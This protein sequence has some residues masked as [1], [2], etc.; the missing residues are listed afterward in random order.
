MIK[1]SNKKFLAFVLFSYGLLF[2]VLALSAPAELVCQLQF[3]KANCWHNYQVNLSI[4]DAVNLQEITAL[5]LDSDELS[6]SSS[7]N[8]TSNQLITFTTDFSPAIWEDQQNR[9]YPAKTI[10]NVP[11][12]LDSD[13]TTWEINLCF[14]DDFSGVPLPP[15]GN[16]VNCRC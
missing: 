4:L 8:C 3:A 5:Q 15:S 14:S 11:S 13:N 9:H 12:D 1:D 10:W 6:V 2:P 7:F 16:L